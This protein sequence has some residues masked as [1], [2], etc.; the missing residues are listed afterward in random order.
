MGHPFRT[1]HTQLDRD[2]ITNIRI[3]V[4]TPNTYGHYVNTKFI[5][6]KI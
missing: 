3:T 5:S 6:V 4:E 1:E 2:Y